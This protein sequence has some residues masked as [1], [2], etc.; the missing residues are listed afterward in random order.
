MSELKN[1]TLCVPKVSKY[2]G[3]DRTAV[4]YLVRSP[5]DRLPSIKVGH[6]LYFDLHE[7]DL[8]LARQPS[9]RLDKMRRTVSQ[10]SI[11]RKPIIKTRPLWRRIIA[12]L[13][14]R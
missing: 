13:I 11:T 9:K 2:L 7:V 1:Y 4:W 8:W 6:H 10:R 5:V 12:A 14:G 3:V